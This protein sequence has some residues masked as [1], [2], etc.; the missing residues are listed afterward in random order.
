LYRAQ[1]LWSGESLVGSGR[2]KE[3][4][5]TKTRTVKEG[6]EDSQDRMVQETFLIEREWTVRIS[7]K[8]RVGGESWREW[9]DY[10]GSSLVSQW[11]TE[12]DNPGDC[13]IRGNGRDLGFGGRVRKC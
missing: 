13:G 2:G 12:W 8:R 5:T 7:M 11:D 9:K 10:E 4:G 1:G 6:K 3:W